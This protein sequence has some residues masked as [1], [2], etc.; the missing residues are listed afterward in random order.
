VKANLKTRWFLCPGCERMAP[1]AGELTAK[2]CEG[3]HIEVM[4]VEEHE[5][6]RN[7]IERECD[8]ALAELEER[9]P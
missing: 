6:I 2:G 9:Q 5:E 7:S 8:D 4:P 3:R 1:T